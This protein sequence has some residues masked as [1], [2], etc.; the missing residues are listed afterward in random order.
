LGLGLSI[1]SLVMAF[2][3]PMPVDPNAPDFVKGFQ[4]GQTGPLAAAIQSAFIV[5]NL[6]IIAAAVQIIRFKQRT[7]GIVMSGLSMVNFGSC[8]C[9][10][11]FPVGL[12]SLIILLQDD[13]AKAFQQ[14]SG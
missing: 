11:G 3:E 13:V 2:G 6:I 4:K 10:L 1:L 12:W 7:F 8:C 9:I 14:N 5:L